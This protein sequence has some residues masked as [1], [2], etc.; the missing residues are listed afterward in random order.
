MKF[1]QYTIVG[2]ILILALGFGIKMYFESMAIAPKR[3][4]D[5]GLKRMVP[6]LEVK[7]E[8]IPIEIEITGKLNAKDKIEIIAEV[9]GRFLG[10]DK[11][12]K[13]GVSFRKG[14]ILVHIDDEEAQLNLKA[15][16]SSFLN[17]L[18]QLLPDLKL[19]YPESFE[20]WESYSAGI[21]VDKPL[22][23]LPDVEDPKERMFITS[24]NIFR[25]FYQIQSQ[26]SR[27][28]KYILRA[29]FDGILSIV[30]INE[31][32]LVRANQVLGDYIAVNGFELEAAVSKQ[33]SN[34]VS[35]GDTVRLKSS[36]KGKE[37]IGRIARKNPYIN[38]Q[39]QSLSLYVEVSGDGLFEG[40]FLSGNIISGKVDD[41][42]SLERKL[43]ID[44][45]KVFAVD[46]SL[47]VLKEVEIIHQSP[48]RLI[49]KG[50]ENG[51]RILENRLNGV[52]EGMSVKPYTY[53]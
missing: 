17:T 10:G 46:D 22:P 45:N 29:P 21:L 32:T 49:V 31:G 4:S 23:E 37:W 25:D 26:Q 16:K 38:P 43:L 18:A 47:L 8:S 34:K 2:G 28:A 11:K 35:I 33:E 36:I 14:E 1:R 7:T 24:R 27:L 13:E 52:Y 53:E 50:L 48:N 44:D 20:K 40:L 15:S 6:V 19:D 51:D 41:A 3:N 5:N 30:N 9:N 42:Y 39:T 12:F